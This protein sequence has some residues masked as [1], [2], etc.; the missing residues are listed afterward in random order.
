M[1]TLQELRRAFDD[2]RR[3]ND[4]LT[5]D[6]DRDR[7][8]IEDLKTRWGRNQ[9][10]SAAVAC[11]HCIQCGCHGVQRR[12]GLSCAHESRWEPCSVPAA[13]LGP[14][15]TQLGCL[16]VHGRRKQAQPP[17]HTHTYMDTHTIAGW[18]APPRSC[19]AR[20]TAAASC[21]TRWS[22]CGTTTQRSRRSSRRRRA[23]GP[24]VRSSARWR[25]ACVFRAAVEVLH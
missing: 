18:S 25:W 1:H 11:A 6:A 12:R 10:F 5:R 8:A 20:M 23:R 13:L 9:V 16:G 21:V 14:V 24:G 2:E 3:A 15:H 19:A 4:D 7:Q 17:P 22:A